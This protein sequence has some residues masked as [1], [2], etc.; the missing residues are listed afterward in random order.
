MQAAPS[1]IANLDD[2]HHFPPVALLFLLLAVLWTVLWFVST[3]R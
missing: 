1:H 2:D 3:L